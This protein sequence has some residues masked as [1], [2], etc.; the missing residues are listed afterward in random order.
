VTKKRP[1]R[2]EPEPTHYVNV[3]LDVYSRVP[4]EGFVQ[5]LGDEAFVLFVG[6]GRRKFEA[7]L[8]LASS[9]MT[10]SADDTIVGLTRLIQSLPRVQRKVW[11]SAQR[12]EFNIGIEAGLEPHGFELRLEQRTLKAV[13]DVDGVLVITVY[14]PDLTEAR[15]PARRRKAPGR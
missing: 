11:D 4:L 5:A 8:E 2:L 1:A 10:M 9:H 7:H 13:T 15:H 14:A 3:D 6:G 12:R